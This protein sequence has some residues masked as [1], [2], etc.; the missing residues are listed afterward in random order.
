MWE[1]P[2]DTSSANDGDYLKYSSNSGLMW[3]ISIPDTDN[4]NS[5]DVL[6]YTDGCGGPQLQWSSP[7]GSLAEVPEGENPLFLGN[8]VPNPSDN[9]DYG[10]TLVIDS[11]GSWGWWRAMPNPSSAQTGDVLTINS[12]GEPE[13]VTPST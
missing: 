13:W 7:G 4:A 10:K 8:Y 9:A 5:G 2:I 3:G 11:C 1:N 6:T 12:N